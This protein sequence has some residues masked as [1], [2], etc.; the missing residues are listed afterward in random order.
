MCPHCL[1]EYQEF[2]DAAE[3]ESLGLPSDWD[4]FKVGDVINFECEDSLMGTRFC[5]SSASGEILFKFMDRKNE[6]EHRTIL[7]VSTR[8][9]DRIVLMGQTDFGECLIGPSEYAY[10]KGYAQDFIAKKMNAAMRDGVQLCDA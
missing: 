1:A 10:Q 8:N 9:S 6:Y 2:P 5:Y 3:C 4:Q 7:L